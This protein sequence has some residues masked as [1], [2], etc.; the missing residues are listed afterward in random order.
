[1]I[2]Q[3]KAILDVAF[4]RAGA[5]VHEQENHHRMVA[6]QICALFEQ[7]EPQEAAL[8]ADLWQMQCAQRDKDMER[9]PAFKER[10]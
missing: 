5:N 4:S 9:Y 1:M 7:P 10:R 8:R 3:I 6:R 2:N